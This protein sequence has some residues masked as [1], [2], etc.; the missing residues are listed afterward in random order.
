MSWSKFIAQQ[1]SALKWV[2][3]SSSRQAMLGTLR[4]KRVGYDETAIAERIAHFRD[5]GMTFGE[6]AAELNTRGWRGRYGGRWY[7]A[8]V[9]AYLLR[10]ISASLSS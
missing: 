1:I 4:A 2:E 9:R 3:R 6:I 7:S 5:R 10:H 8:S